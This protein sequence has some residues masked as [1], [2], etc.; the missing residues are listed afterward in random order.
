M[1]AAFAERSAFAFGKY[2]V[3]LIKPGDHRVI[4]L[5]NI[6]LRHNINFHPRSSNV[7]EFYFIAKGAKSFI[8]EHY[9]TFARA[10]HSAMGA[11]FAERSAFAFGKY[12]A[13]LIKPS[14]HC[15][16]S[17]LNISIKYNIK[18]SILSLPSSFLSKKLNLITNVIA[19]SS[20]PEINLYKI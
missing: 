19:S 18:T 16:I 4:S 20:V 11:V 7:Q 14:D 17:L 9:K 5:L 2:G 3:R 15:V 6:S 1:G 13:R 10:L 12:G 8:I